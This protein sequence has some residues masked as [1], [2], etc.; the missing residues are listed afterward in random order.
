[1]HNNEVSW[2]EARRIYESIKDKRPKKI[3]AERRNAKGTKWT[4]PQL[5]SSNKR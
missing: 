3:G 1:M 2:K 5:F 4:M